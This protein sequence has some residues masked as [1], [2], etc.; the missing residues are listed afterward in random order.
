MPTFDAQLVYF[1]SFQ[2]YRLLIRT[3]LPQCTLRS[4]GSSF[5]S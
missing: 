3:Q 5:S 1:S 2:T 4:H